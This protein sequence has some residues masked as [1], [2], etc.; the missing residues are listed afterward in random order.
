MKHELKEL[1]NRVNSLRPAW[2]KLAA[3]TYMEMD[4]LR[5][6]Q[7]TLAQLT[8][9]DWE[10]IRDFFAYTPRDRE[11]FPRVVKKASF[12]MDPSGTLAAAEE[13]AKTHRRAKLPATIAVVRRQESGDMTKEEAIKLL[14]GDQ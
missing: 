13:W 12:M 2:S 3:L 1:I 4:A 5:Q 8:D 14:R 11:H 7:E 6:G 10:L 9:G